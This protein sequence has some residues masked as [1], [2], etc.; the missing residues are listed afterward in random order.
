MTNCRLLPGAPRSRHG[1]HQVW[2]HHPELPPR[3]ASGIPYD[4]DVAVGT[5][6]Y[7]AT[8][9]HPTLG[10]ALANAGEGAVVGFVAGTGI[11]LVGLGLV[12]G[13]AHMTQKILT[14]ASSHDMARYG[15]SHLSQTAVAGGD[16][17]EGAVEAVAGG[18]AGEVLGG[19]LLSMGGK[20]LAEHSATI[21]S[22][23]RSVTTAV[24]TQGSKPAADAAIS[25]ATGKLENKVDKAECGK[26][27]SH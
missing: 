8:T 5:A 6:S 15:D 24:V 1:L 26:A 17:A 10:G 25:V 2:G 14:S 23:A 20:L 3:C 19:K 13:A 12:G 9:E 4:P 22:G 27:C 11:G 16:F 21:T 7:Y 18:K